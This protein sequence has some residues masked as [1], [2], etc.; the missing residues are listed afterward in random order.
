V[1]V[2]HFENP[3]PMKLEKQKEAILILDNLPAH[4]I[5]RLLK[6]LNLTRIR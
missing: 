6:I 3:R 2:T 4:K 5:E 1:V